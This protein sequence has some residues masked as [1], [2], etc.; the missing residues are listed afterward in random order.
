VSI[1]GNN[2]GCS[3][4]CGCIVVILLFAILLSINPWAFVGAALGL[5][6]VFLF[7]STS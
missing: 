2:D 4:D 1:E 6:I 7:F 3:I 5:A